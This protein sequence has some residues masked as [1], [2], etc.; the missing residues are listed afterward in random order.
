MP[1]HHTDQ[2]CSF[3]VE[4]FLKLRLRHF[5]HRYPAVVL[6][7]YNLTGASA[8]LQMAHLAGQLARHEAYA[9]FV[10]GGA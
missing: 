7:D 6:R 3:F 5:R 9:S 10:K 8:D 2:L 4:M 1:L